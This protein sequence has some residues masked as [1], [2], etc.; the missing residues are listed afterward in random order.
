[1]R[2]SP[3]HFSDLK[4]KRR[5]LKTSETR[6][7]FKVVLSKSWSQDL[8][9]GQKTPEGLKMVS[10]NPGYFDNNSIFLL[11]FLKQINTVVLQQ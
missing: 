10:V 6:H 1:M 8:M 9:G 3:G 7:V 11:I 4:Q 2:H 5:L